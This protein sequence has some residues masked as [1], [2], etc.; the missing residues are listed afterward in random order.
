MKIRLLL[1][2]M[3]IGLPLLSGAAAQA[4]SGTF[5]TLAYNVAGLPQVLSSAAGDRSVATKLISCLAASKVK[6][7]A[8]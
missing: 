7:R 3:I 5:S 2:T 6:P 1:R 4:A 8:A